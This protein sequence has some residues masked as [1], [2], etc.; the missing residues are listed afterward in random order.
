M[1]SV[2]RSSTDLL[3]ATL[4][5]LFAGQISA[6]EARKDA[7]AVIGEIHFFGDDEPARANQSKFESLEL[8]DFERFS[9]V[10]EL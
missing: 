9:A 8:D 5:V 6:Q 7:K 10:E 3:V 1:F 4:L 2:L